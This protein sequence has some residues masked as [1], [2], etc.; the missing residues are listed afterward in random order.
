MKGDKMQ[1]LSVQAKITKQEITTQ[2]RYNLC[3]HIIKQ[4]MFPTQTIE[5]PYV[6]QITQQRQSQAST[7]VT[8]LQRSGFLTQQETLV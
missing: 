3:M 7:A 6:P 2:D 8:T 5:A 4:I 1:T